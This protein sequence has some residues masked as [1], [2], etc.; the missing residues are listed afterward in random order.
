MRVFAPRANLLKSLLNPLFAIALVLSAATLAADIPPHGSAYLLVID[1]SES[2]SANMSSGKT[3][4]EEMQDTFCEFIDTTPL[5]SHIWLAVFSSKIEVVKEW[6]V[7][8]DQDRSQIQQ[9]IRTYSAPRGQTAFYDAWGKALEYAQHLSKARSVRSIFIKAFTDGEDTSSKLTRAD[10][11]K[12]MAELTAENNRVIFRVN[13]IGNVKPPLARELCTN[14]PKDIPLLVAVD[15]YPPGDVQLENPNLHKNQSIR[16]RLIVSDERLE[17]LKAAS[18]GAALESTVTYIPDPATPVS[19]KTTQFKI[20]FDNREFQIPVDV[21]NAEQLKIDQKY[22]A[23]LSITY[24]KIK[25]FEFL[26]AER[27]NVVFNK[28]EGL[29]IGDSD[30]RPRDGES[31]PVGQSILFYVNS[32]QNGKVLWD[33]GDGSREQGAEVRYAYNKPGVY[34]VTL[35]VDAGPGRVAAK[36]INLK[37]ILVEAAVNPVK[38]P[39]FV[40]ETVALSCAIRGEVDRCRWLIDG[41]EFID[42]RGKGDQLAHVFTNPGRHTIKVAAIADKCTVYSRELTIDALPRPAI[43]IIEPQAS[44]HF[45]YGQKVQFRATVDG[46]VKAVHWEIT[47]KDGKS[48]FQVDRPVA[49]EAGK[50][51]VIMEYTFEEASKLSDVLIT[52]KAKL[53]DG[54]SLTPPSATIP[55]VIDASGRVVRIIKPAAGSRVEFGKRVVFEAELDG[56]NMSQ[57]QWAL[58]ANGKQLFQPKL[59]NAVDEAGRRIARLEHTFEDGPAEMEVSIEASGVLPEQ[60]KEKTPRDVA[61]LAVYW[62]DIQAAIAVQNKT[63]GLNEPVSFQVQCAQPV[64]SIHWDFGDGSAPLTVTNLNPVHH[65]YSRP[66]AQTVTAKVSGK[67]GKSTEATATISIVTNP[68]KAAAKLLSNGTPI[69]K[70]YPDTLIELKDESTGDIITREWLLNGKPLEKGAASLPLKT[71]GT[72]ELKLRVSG[73]PDAAG[74]PVSDE[75]VFSLVVLKKPETV[76]F[77]LGAALGL[78]IFAVLAYYMTGNGARDWTLEYMTFD[79]GDGK[80][81]AAHYARLPVREEEWPPAQTLGELHYSAWTKKSVIP[82]KKLFDSPHWTSGAGK[83]DDLIINTELG[84]VRFTNSDFPLVEM[85]NSLNDKQ[86]VYVLMD[87][88][89]EKDETRNIRLR[90][91]RAASDS[92]THLIVLFVALIALGAAIWW[93]AERTL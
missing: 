25:R 51:N 70:L 80:Q 32:V 72:H 24:P 12:R 37:I 33:F 4:W 35:K 8:T 50:K 9:F 91:T 46:P 3:R 2:M 78:I 17:R 11:E 41:D 64:Q 65:A 73:P 83:N 5:H 59:A 82:L 36:K 57:V 19:I 27:V 38:G 13:L 28:G 89:G 6:R 92:H 45:I 69:A 21:I 29:E 93:W 14:N 43:A 23:A 74:Q 61:R 16:M 26:G 79:A 71:I 76:L 22:R 39:V 44:K 66:G 49:D 1:H 30:F 34:P 58:Q 68:P 85:P 84:T 90:L 40:G 81:G 47:S 18:A 86:K 53:E 54:I 15:V 10:C 63:F 52:A 62:P 56:P 60:L 67:G 87:T 20:P 75:V 55:L 31:F 48:V 7:S 77:W 88:R 42:P